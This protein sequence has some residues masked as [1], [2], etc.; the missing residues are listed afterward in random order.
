[1]ET[2]KKQK[3]SR[4][5][6]EKQ[7]WFIIHLDIYNHDILV[8]FGSDHMHLQGILKR[9]IK[10]DDVKVFDGEYLALCGMFKDGQLCIHFKEI[11]KRASQFGRMAHEIHHAVTFL[12]KKLDTPLSD[13]TM[14][15]Y[16]YLTGFIYTQ[17]LKRIWN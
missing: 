1:M 10:N 7:K 4:R 9:Y 2:T 12:F 15:P 5:R 8:Y 16:A 6:T 13:D 11:P 14:E 17:I 3:P